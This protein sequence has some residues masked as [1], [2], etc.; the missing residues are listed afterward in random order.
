MGN[1]QDLKHSFDNFLLAQ[2]E[3]AASGV[4][5]GGK[6]LAAVFKYHLRCCNRGTTFTGLIPKVY[7]YEGGSELAKTYQFSGGK[8]TLYGSREVRKMFL[9]RCLHSQHLI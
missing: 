6:K 7:F 4:Q 3:S 2:S 5:I 9:V 8:V 1:Y